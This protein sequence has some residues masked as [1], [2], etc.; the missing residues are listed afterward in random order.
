LYTHGIPN[1]PVTRCT[2]NAFTMLRASYLSV[3]FQESVMMRNLFGSRTKQV[4]PRASIRS[5][6]QNVPEQASRITASSGPRSSMYLR[7]S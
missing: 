1:S 4:A 6:Y 2:H 5:A 7:R 3:F